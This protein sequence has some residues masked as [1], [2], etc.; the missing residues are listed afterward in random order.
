MIQVYRNVIFIAEL[1]VNELFSIVVSA[2]TQRHKLRVNL[3]KQKRKMDS[4]ITG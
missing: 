2:K 4:R 3:W 1:M